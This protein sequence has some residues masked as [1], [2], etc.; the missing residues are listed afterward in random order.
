MNKL[1]KVLNIMGIITI[2]VILIFT[3]WFVVEF[4]EMLNDHRCYNL[5]LNEFYQDKK[6]ER[7]WDLSIWNNK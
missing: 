2:I 7:Y 5:P 1:E 6:C 3:I 4:R